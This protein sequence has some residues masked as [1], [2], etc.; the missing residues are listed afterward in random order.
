MEGGDMASHLLSKTKYLTGLQCPRLIWI[1]VNEPEKMPETDPVTQYIFDQGHEV[2]YLAK[3]LFP[4]G[5][6]IPADDFMGNIWKTKELLKERK[7]LFEAGILAG[8][9]YSRVD[10][11]S[12]A[13]EEEWDIA[14]VKSSTSVKK[15]HIDDVAYQ[16]HCCT[17]AGL[18]IRNC[19]L[20]LINNQYVRDREID[21]E[22]LFN[23]HDVTDKVEEAS[24]GIEDSI[25]GI[26]EVVSR[27]TCPEMIIGPHC[28]DPYECSL[29]DCWDYLPEH[30]VFTLYWGG[31]KSF[32]MYDS[33]IVTI[34]EIPDDYKL[35]DKQFIQKASI[36]SGEPYIDGEAIREFLSGLEY[37]LYYLDFE[38]IGPVVPLF[39]GVRSYQN[40]P[41][42][43]SLH[44][45][46]D[47]K[48][49]PMHYSYLSSS[50]SDPRPGL[51]TEL[52]KVLGYSGSIIA[53]NKGFEEGCLCDIAAAF[54]EYND[55]I[56]QVCGRLV[57]LLT[58]FSNF[59]YYHP[60]QK[61]S[62]SLK[63]VLPAITGK[64]YED[65]D[66][67]DGQVASFIFLAANYGE[68][69]EADR[70]KVMDKLEEYCGR[71][72]EGMIWIVDKLKELSN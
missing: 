58:P 16:R 37:P 60:A 38:T 27:E 43:Y 40:I 36:I 2:G 10:I 31:K 41:F 72:T 9:L 6:D 11:L 67:S 1:D 45:V 21:P 65:L 52:Q 62:A 17:Q 7:P 24:V 39:D 49:E 69:P 63:S 20:V 32:T 34:R 22:G 14:E 29:S 42:Q 44:I 53:Y 19:Y 33:G 8:K 25:N 68:M 66:I 18:N 46:Q 54:P 57:D 51:L 61:G 59:Y 13:N 15:V 71:D 35:N 30:N 23:V 26:L 48:S 4:R 3:K 28:R 47:E 56:E 12:P 64:G 50:T 5:I 70:A 55:W